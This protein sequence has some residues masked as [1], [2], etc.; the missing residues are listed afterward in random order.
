MIKLTSIQSVSQKPSWV[1]YD[2]VQVPSVSV[3]L[4]KGECNYHVNLV[5]SIKVRV[6]VHDRQIPGKE[7][8]CPWIR[9]YDRRLMFET[10]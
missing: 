6:K 4:A 7:T 9:I 1:L 5:H 3:H 2:N 8:F 10:L